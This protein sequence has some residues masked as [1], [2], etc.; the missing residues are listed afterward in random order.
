LSS[1]ELLVVLP[2][3]ALLTAAPE[4]SNHFAALFSVV[5]SLKIVAVCDCVAEIGIA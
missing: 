5:Y 1:A 3:L 4:N 2:L